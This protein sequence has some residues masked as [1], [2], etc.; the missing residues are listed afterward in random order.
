MGFA[1][2]IIVNLILNRSRTKAKCIYLKPKKFEVKF[3]T[4]PLTVTN[5]LIS[6]NTE[7]FTI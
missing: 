4:K 5:Q 1:L 6:K 3:L 7:T 2:Y